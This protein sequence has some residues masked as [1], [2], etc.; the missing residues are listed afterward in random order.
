ML[1]KVWYVIYTLNGVDKSRIWFLN[2]NSNRFFT[3]SGVLGFLVLENHV[4]FNVSE[5]FLVSENPASFAHLKI[6]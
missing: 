3:T 6:F 1:K 2:I 4:L 5:L